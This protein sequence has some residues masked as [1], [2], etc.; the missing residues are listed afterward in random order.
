MTLQHP[1]PHNAQA[2]FHLTDVEIVSNGQAQENN[3]F[4]MVGTASPRNISCL[5]QSIQ[6][7]EANVTWFFHSGLAL[8]LTGADG[9]IH[10]VDA[11]S[12]SDRRVESILVWSPQLSDDEVVSGG[13]FYCCHISTPRGLQETACIGLFHQDP[14]EWAAGVKVQASEEVLLTY[15][16]I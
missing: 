1:C 2:F 10:Q 11:S 14:S 4:I 6:F 12:S 9:S 8:P 15:V 16:H 7:F 5:L 3:S 13:G